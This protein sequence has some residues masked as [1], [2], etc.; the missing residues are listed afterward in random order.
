MSPEE[1]Q[2]ALDNI[3]E[4]DLAKIQAKMAK[5]VPVDIEDIIEAEFLMKFGFSA[6]WALYPDKNPSEG[7][8]GSDMSR[9]LAASRKLDAGKVYMDMQAAFVGA[10][11]AKSKSPSA[12]FRKLTA[13]LLKSTEAN[14]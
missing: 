12:T 13:S 14:T 6:Y 2:A 4:A 11:S 8:S 3:S 1:R 9:L 10:A 7:I 5:K